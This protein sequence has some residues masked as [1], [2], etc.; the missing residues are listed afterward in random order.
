MQLITVLVLQLYYN[1]QSWLF[2]IIQFYFNI[3][4]AMTDPTK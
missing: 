1:M 3:N 4:T 2:D